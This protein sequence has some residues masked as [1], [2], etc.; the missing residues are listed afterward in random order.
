MIKVGVSPLLLRAGL[1]YQLRHRWQAF[2]A[3]VGIV[4]GVAVVL[5]VDLANGAARASF[6]LSSAQIRGAATHRIIGNNGE[7]EQALYAQLFTTPG[8]PPM[9]PVINSKL[10]INGYKGGFRLIGLDLFA[11]SQFRKAL[12]SAIRNTE[13]LGEWLS[14]PQAVA[15]SQ[16]AAEYLGVALNATLTARY[17][18][19]RHDLKVMII[20]PSN[21]S[22][23]R[24]LLVVDIATAQVITAKQ[25]SITYIDLI[26]NVDDKNWLNGK[27]PQSVKLVDVDQQSEGIVGL[28]ADF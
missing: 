26:L 24:D 16:S 12:P 3:L 20:N 4:M 1:N 17:Q 7:V 13:Q 27:L 25:R 11:E 21:S 5:A 19:Q 18:G 23:S 6:A 15:I 10:Q 22:V 8:H 14:D 2:L 28:S 9:A